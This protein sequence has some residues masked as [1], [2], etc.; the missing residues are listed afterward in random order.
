MR[1]GRARSADHMVT[2]L[3]VSTGLPSSRSSARDHVV[4]RQVGAADE[5]RLGV[6][7][8]GVADEFGGDL[9]GH[10]PDLARSA[11]ARPWRPPRHRPRRERWSSP[12]VRSSV[13]GV[14]VAIR[15]MPRCRSAIQQCAAGGH[16]RG[17]AGVLHRG[18]QCGLAGEAADE[19]ARR[20]GVGGDQGRDGAG[21][22]SRCG[23]PGRGSE[24]WMRHLERRG[25]R[26]VGHPGEVQADVVGHPAPQLAVQG[27]VVGRDD[28]DPGLQQRRGMAHGAQC[29]GTLRSRK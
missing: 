26:D 23:R 16:R 1:P 25:E 3:A 2:W 10:R 9:V 17:R 6:G 13:Y 14:T 29:G 4:R 11:R 7:G 18:D 12:S 22:R 8:V 19:A 24:M 15:V 20:A 21:R 28:T 27:E 5:D